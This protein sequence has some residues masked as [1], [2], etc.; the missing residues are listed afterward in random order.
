[1]ARQN[2]V[3][4]FGEIV[5]VPERGTVMGN[6]GALHDEDGRIRRPWQV[7]RWLLCRLEFNGR[8]RVVMAPNRYTELFFLDEATG[9]AAGHRPC[10]ECRRKSFESYA[11][12]WARGNLQAGRPTATA[13]D[14]RL[15]AERVGPNRSKRTS[16][17]AIA[18]LPDGVFVTLGE[19]GDVARLLWRGRLLAWSPGGYTSSL[20]PPGRGEVAVLTPRSTIDAIRAGYVPEVHASAKEPRP[21]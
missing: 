9:L 15:Q 10:F 14:G 19:D 21:S 8:H 2:R 12:A 1:M 6:R 4:P 17:A 7:K 20:S 5:A 3:T 11:D 16:R 13:I 18:D